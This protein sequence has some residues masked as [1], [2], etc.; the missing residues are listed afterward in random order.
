MLIIAG[1]EFYICR[2]YAALIL[3]KIYFFYHIVGAMHL[4]ESQ[5]A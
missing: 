3:I 4:S 2:R 1:D 5:A